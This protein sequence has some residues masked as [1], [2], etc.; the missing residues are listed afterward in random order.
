M[1]LFWLSISF[2][3]GILL[4]ALQPLA[5]QVW[6]AL[7]GLAFLLAVFS[8]HISLFSWEHWGRAL[9]WLFGCL[10][11]WGVRG[12][13]SIRK[14]IARMR[15]ATPWLLVALCLGGARYQAAQPSISPND[16]AFYNETKASIVLE[17]WL[18]EPPDLRD[19][20]SL[21]RFQVDWINVSGQ[22]REI[23]VEGRL[24]VRSD[25]GLRWEYGDR[26]R[27]EGY[28]VDPPDQEGFSYRQYLARQGIYAYMATGNILHVGSEEGSS[29]IAAAY[30][31]RQR[32]LDL[33]YTFWQDPEASLL[34]GILLGV[35]TGIPA[36]LAAAFRDTGTAHIIAISGSNI[37]IL[38]GFIALTLGRLLDARRRFWVAGLSTILVLGYAF[39][40]GWDAA[41]VRAAIMGGVAL[42]AAPFGRTP[43]GLNS[44][45]FVAAIM[46]L[47]TP[48]ILWDVSFQLSFMAT[49]GLVLFAVPFSETFSRMITRWWGEGWA[50][51][52][53][54]PIGEY[55]LFT[56]AAQLTTLPVILA[57]FGRLSAIGLLA[58]PLILPA[59]P[60][61]MASGGMALLS[62]VLVQSLGH[63]FAWF[64]WP[65]MRYTIAVVELLERVP[66]AAWSTGPI[67]P[68]ILLGYTALI[69][70]AGLFWEP[71]INL[72]RRLADLLGGK[73]ASVGLLTLI[74]LTSLVW[75]SA[76]R[77]PDE[78]LH[79][80]LLDTGGGEALLIQTRTGRHILINGGARAS[81]LSSELG[82]RLPLIN[83]RLDWL[84][85]SGTRDEQIGALPVTI[86]RY[87]P[88]AVLWAGPTAG[89]ASAR[90]LYRQLGEDQLELIEPQVGQALD[91]GDG[92][93]LE[94]LVITTRGAVFLLEW[95]EFRA[96]LPVGIDFN[97]LEALLARQDLAPLSA[98]LLPDNGYA[99]L[100]PPEL[101]TTLQP[102]VVLLSVTA[103]NR[104]ELPSPETLKALQGFTLLRTDQNG[105][106]ELMTD[107][108]QMWVEVEKK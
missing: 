75:R 78:R 15:I 57:Q 72:L 31:L 46:A 101:F 47:I 52:L 64:A 97:A 32:A 7:A 77:A 56:M 94:F 80:T 85:V 4:A 35:E 30:H 45:A 19:Q 12:I 18:V 37:A 54:G 48:T 105:W 8:W 16:L 79:L 38:A 104:E 34:A 42:F 106:I 59:Q 20:Y 23:A 74:V 87:P 99:P 21:L 89:S 102:Q 103:G 49:L 62:G 95:K 44:L 73:A 90:T 91:L 70:A 24:L 96:L 17:G 53:T 68:V 33:V 1:P 108:N 58:N 100:N 5:I 40:V 41:V 63:F 50:A 66:G 81:Q 10:P 3:A 76:L 26:L 2:L 39:L 43:N 14:A 82:R 60:V 22:D 93:R 51:R 107:G 98:L 9:G 36:D 29:L 11:L 61:V 13:V 71:L 6:L 92:A 67:S 65:F 55:V 27:L 69:L 83:R 28:L 86:V 88:G 25:P 84:V